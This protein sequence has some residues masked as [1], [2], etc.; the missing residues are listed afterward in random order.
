VRIEIGDGRTVLAREGGHCEVLQASLVDTWAAT[1]AGAFAHTEA[2]LYTREAWAVFLRRVEPNGILT[3]S[4]WFDETR[5]GEAS[6]LVALAIASLL[7]RGVE[8]VGEHV[9]LVTAGRVATVLVSPEAF[10]SEDRRRL[11]ELEAKYGFR[12]A[13]FPGRPPADP[14]LRQL[15]TARSVGEL[16]EAGAPQRLDT[17]APTDERPF[18]FQ[19]V[20]PGAWLHPLA[21]LRARSAG[22]I[23]GNTTATLRLLVTF[24]AAVLLGLVLLGPTLIAAA[25]ATP[26]PRQDARAWMYFGALGAGFMLTEIALVQRLH[27]VLGH[28]SYALIAVLAGLLVATGVGSAFSPSLV[29]TRRA[30]SVA[31]VCAA[32]ALIALPSVIRLLA[33]ATSEA[34]LALRMAW[35]GA[36]AGVVGIVLGTLFPSGLKF[37]DRAQDA[38]V[39][40]A[41]NGVASVLGSTAAILVSVWLG[42]PATFFFAAIVYLLAA[43]VG[44]VAWPSY[45]P[46]TAT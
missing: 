31:A 16:S 26:S 20:A 34:P 4:R 2:T 9:A 7:D 6:R 43:A 3:F 45:G 14:L 40:L 15:M 42:I 12:V 23:E 27:V 36:C 21:V 44:P 19:L 17:S 18:F 46:R 10:S 1:G 39:A 28:P 22:V 8:T 13:V 41:L 24:V 38:Q 11:E 33:H 37:C 29:R 35:S 5:L 30:V 25:R 32:L